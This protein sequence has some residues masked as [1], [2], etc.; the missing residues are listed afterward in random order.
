MGFVGN[1]GLNL[2]TEIDTNLYKINYFIFSYVRH[3]PLADKAT[4][5]YR[6]EQTDT[7]QKCKGRIQIRGNQVIKHCDPSNH[8]HEGNPFKHKIQEVI[9]YIYLAI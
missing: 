3:Q 6:C 5:S 1:Y 4:V 2:L 9:V 8:N 7:K